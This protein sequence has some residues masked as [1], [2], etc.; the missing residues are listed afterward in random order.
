MIQYIFNQAA[1]PQTFSTRQ[2]ARLRRLWLRF[3]DP[4]IEWELEG[5]KLRLPLSHDLPFTYRDHPLFCRNL[6]RLCQWVRTR[7]SELRMIDVG[8]NVGDSWC[9][10]RPIDGDR[11]LLVEGSP[12]Y[13]DIL[14]KNTAGTPGVSVINALIDE[15]PGTPGGTF[16]LREG[17][18][19]VVPGPGGSVPKATLDQLTAPPDGGVG[20]NL[21]KTDIDGFDLRA[22]H[23][24][25]DLLRRDRPVVFLEFHPNL[26]D[27]AG[28]DPLR[29]F[30][31]FK[32]LDYPHLLVYDN[33]G[34]LIGE[35]QTS[36]TDRW[37][38]L[39][40]LARARPYYYF[41]IAAF[42]AEDPEGFRTFHQREQ[43]YF[44]RDVPRQFS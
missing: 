29:L 24:A 16:I 37:R 28:D 41:D 12:R 38:Q 35:F 9:L 1:G 21:L 10:A 34:Y 13:H 7:S 42:P 44:E 25:R 30:S 5:R 2:F 3:S 14:L 31:L 39:I 20:W 36:D 22:L 4:L 19:R 23:G 26:L 40:L 33:A 27:T 18:A 17:T 43:A 32:S 15:T 6:T 8:A 11:F